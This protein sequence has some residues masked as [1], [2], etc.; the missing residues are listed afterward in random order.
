MPEATPSPDRA[1]RLANP[2]RNKEIGRREGQ[3]ED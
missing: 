3:R 1:A 2:Y